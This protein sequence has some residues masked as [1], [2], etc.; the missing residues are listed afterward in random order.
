MVEQVAQEG[1]LP[2]R[3]LSEYSSYIHGFHHYT[4]QAER[5]GGGVAH[6]V[7]AVL[8]DGHYSGQGPK[9]YPGRRSTSWVYKEM[10]FILG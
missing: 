9:L 1:P 4:E 5:G 7:L 3:I 6:L 10:S 2:Y 8:T